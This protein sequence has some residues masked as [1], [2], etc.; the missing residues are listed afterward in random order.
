MKSYADTEQRRDYL[1]ALARQSSNLEQRAESAE[2]DLHA[3]KATRYLAAR[4]GQEFAGVVTG[5]TPGGLTVQLTETGMDG[6]VPLRELKDDF[7]NYDPERYALVGKRSGRVI[8]IGEH[9]DVLVASA[10]IERCDVVLSLVQR[11]RPRSAMDEGDGESRRFSQRNPNGRK[12]AGKGAREPAPKPS[13][14][15]SKNAARLA[16]QEA[17]REDRKRRHLERLAKTKNK[18]K[19]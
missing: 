6:F 12:P 16:N 7:Y 5:A 13:P 19:A 10:D 14:R 4:L 3:R 18:G 9:L 2:R 8:G 1:D 11:Q 15:D 17:K